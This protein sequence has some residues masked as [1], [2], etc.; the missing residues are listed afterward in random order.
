MKVIREGDQEI[1]QYGIKRRL[2]DMWK[3]L[4]EV[5]CPKCKTIFETSRSWFRGR[6]NYIQT[7]PRCLHPHIE[8]DTN[9]KVK[10]YAYE[11]YGPKPKNWLSLNQR[12][13][14]YIFGAIIGVLLSIII[15]R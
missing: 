7:C 15:F 3:D 6:S 1:I 9:T 8:M 13:L 2:G 10:Q 5:E 14:L 11:I 4:L 12:I